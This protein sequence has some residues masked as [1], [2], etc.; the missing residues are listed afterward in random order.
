MEAF[1]KVLL[2]GAGGALGANARYWLG[3]WILA[4]SQE[5]LHST[6]PWGNFVINI[7]G[8]L[9][10]GLFMGMFLQLRW[11]PNWQ[12]FVAIGVLGGYTTFSSFAYEAL[13]LLGGREYLKA[14]F[15]IEGSALLTVL[16]AWIGLVL[17]RVIL[18]GRV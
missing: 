4:W 18:G 11:H 2:I 5:K 10:I 12:L 1:S 3:G 8:S 14:L 17:A 15:F 9:I 7:S 16:A 6:F 13:N